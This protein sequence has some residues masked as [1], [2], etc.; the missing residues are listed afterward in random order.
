MCESRR[1]VLALV[2]RTVRQR[3][4]TSSLWLA[5]RARRLPTRSCTLTLFPKHRFPVTSSLAQI[6]IASSAL[7]SGL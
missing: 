7:K 6:Q 2:C 5:K 4:L 3:S 1:R